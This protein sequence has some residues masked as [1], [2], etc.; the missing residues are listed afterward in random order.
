LAGRSVGR[1]MLNGSVPVAEVTEVMDITRREESTGGERVNG[2]ITPLV[3]S[4]RI[5]WQT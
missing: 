4:V 3:Q 2:S 5:P 1:A